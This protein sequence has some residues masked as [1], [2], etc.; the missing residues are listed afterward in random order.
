MTP[1]K[2][3]IAGAA[4]SILMLALALP[5]IAQSQRVPATVVNPTTSDQ[6]ATVIVPITALDHAPALV[7]LGT[8]RDV[9]GR[10]VQGYMFIHYKD[11]YTHRP[12]HGGGGGAASACYSYLARG[13]KWKTIEAY[14]VDPT[15]NQGLLDAFVRATIAGAVG[16]WED[17]ADGVVGNNTAVNIMGDEE[18]GIVDGVDTVTPDG[19]NEVLFGD[20]SD[21]NAI[22]VTVVWG[23]FGGAPGNRELVEWD[24]LYDQVDF[25]WSATGETGKMDFDNIATHEKGHAFGMG[26]PDDSCNEETMYRFA[27]T[28][29]T[30]KQD[31]NA[32]DIAG[33]NGLY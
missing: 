13:A 12:K 17:A 23:V 25:T 2:H 28:G 18:G 10:L 19:K 26:H 11:A 20:I 30:K 32:G 6:R 4:I 21:A 27:A 33:I 22:A 15:N 24:Q 9:D 31:L 14:R 29:E 1:I 3:T 5:V 8:A 7:E 16:K